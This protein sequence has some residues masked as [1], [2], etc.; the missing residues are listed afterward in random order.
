M[1]EKELAFV[2]KQ[3]DEFTEKA[4]LKKCPKLETFKSIFSPARA[5]GISNRLLISE[6]FLELWQKGSYDE[7]D[8]DALLAHEFG[9][10][11]AYPKSRF[12]AAANIIILFL[13]AVVLLTILVFYWSLR[14]PEPGII[15]ALIMGCWFFLMPWVVRRLYVPGEFEAD[16][17]AVAFKLTDPQQLA[18]ALLKRMSM[19]RRRNLGPS[20]TLGLLWQ[21]L[22]HP[23]LNETLENLGLEIRHAVEF[24]K[25]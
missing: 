15:T 18:D 10:F 4:H 11:I 8:V 7:K 19:Q 13:C 2:N 20:Q 23:S 9:H 6:N 14:I 24:R 21:M 1:Y 3:I 5:D 16:H 22:T 25:M 12:G 17:N